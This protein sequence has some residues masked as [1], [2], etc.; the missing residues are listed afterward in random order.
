MIH[1]HFKHCDFVLRLEA[2]ELQRHAKVVVEIA[3][4]LQDLELF[5][6]DSGDALLRC[7]LAG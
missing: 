5:S 4:G 1:A 6:E 7:R 3:G 2:Q